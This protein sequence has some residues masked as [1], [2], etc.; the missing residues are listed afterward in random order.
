MQQPLPAIP[1]RHCWN[2]GKFVQDDPYCAYC[3]EAKTRR[4]NQQAW[5]VPKL[6][7]KSLTTIV[8]VAL[9]LMAIPCGIGM[10][11]TCTVSGIDCFGNGE[12]IGIIGHPIVKTHSDIGIDFFES[13]ET[14]DIH[15]IV[16]P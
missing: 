8:A 1:S 15:P 10:A 7:G 12:S 3:G 11:V 5:H 14:I 6:S 2:C 16:V 13:G 9:W 4:F